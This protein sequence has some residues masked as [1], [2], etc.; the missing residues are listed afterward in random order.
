MQILKLTLLALLAVACSDSKFSSATGAKKN[1]SENQQP[2]P[3]KS[4][5]ASGLSGDQASM[6]ASNKTIGSE[7]DTTT[8]KPL[9]CTS[10]NVSFSPSQGAVCA[11][12]TVAY[13]IDDGT[14]NHV[15]CCPLPAHDILTAGA[16]AQRGSACGS[17]EVAVGINQGGFMCAKINTARYKLASP[18]ATC[19]I[20]NGASGDRGAGP[21]GAPNATIRAMTSKFGKDACVGSPF[22]SMVVSKTSKY[23]GGMKTMQLFFNDT[24]AAVPMFP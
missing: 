17:N 13:A 8:H 1:K 16:P 14:F 5:N 21:C 23:C 3:A 15:A 10:A 7:E 22:G 4:E 20:G 11:K 9:E 6:S 19:Y 12:N 24:G 18:R 2:D